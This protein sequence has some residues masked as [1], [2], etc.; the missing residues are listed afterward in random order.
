MM[1]PLHLHHLKQIHALLVQARR[2]L[3]RIP[4]IVQID[5]DD[6]DELQ[7]HLNRAQYRAEAILSGE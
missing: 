7:T 4:T 5:N 1:D 3:D 6:F 2:H